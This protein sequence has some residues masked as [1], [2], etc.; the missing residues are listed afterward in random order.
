MAVIYLKHP[1]HG[2]KVACSDMEAEYDM[3]QGWEPFDPNEP[4]SVA[5]APVAAPAPVQEA[6]EPV[7]LLTEPRRRRRKEVQNGYH[8]G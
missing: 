2:A 4:A 5:P 7:N 6:P 1:V 8:G 3:N